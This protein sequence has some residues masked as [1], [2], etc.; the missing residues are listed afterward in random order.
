MSLLNQ[1]Y[2][3]PEV[4]AIARKERER[5]AV[6]TRD[7]D[8]LSHHKTVRQA[9]KWIERR[10]KIDPTGV[11]NGE[12]T[13]DASPQAD[14]EYQRLRRRDSKKP[15]TRT[16]H[17]IVGTGPNKEG[18]MFVEVAFDTRNRKALICVI[19]TVPA[20][21]YKPKVSHPNSEVWY[22]VMVGKKV[23]SRHKAYGKALRAYR[24]I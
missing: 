19:D 12:Y 5:K 20:F 13:I 22:E 21:M 15:A 7:G 4:E 9:E 14:A 3:H 8:I 1:P 17:S 23:K 18:L 10:A 11:A 16:F 24:M 2:T 6:V